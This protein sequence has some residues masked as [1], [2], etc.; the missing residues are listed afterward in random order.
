MSMAYDLRLSLTHS[1]ESPADN[2]RHILRV[3][4]KSI[5][6]QQ[7][8][9]ACLL[10]VLPEPEE[11]FDGT[12]FFGNAT[13]TVV[14][15]E[16]HDKMEIRMSARVELSPPPYVQGAFS[17]FEDLEDSLRRSRDLSSGSPL[18]FLG[19]SPRLSPD[20]E[21]AAFAASLFRPGDGVFTNVVRIGE[22]L[23]DLM[24]FDATATTVDTDPVDAFRHRRGVCQDYSHI[25]ILALRSLGI[26]AG[27]VSGFLR[28]VPPPGGLR[29]EGADAMH[30]WVQ[31][32]C[33]PVG[34]WMQYDP[35]NACLP[36]TDHIV[37][38]L[39]RDYADVSPIIGHLRASGELTSAQA[40]DVI[41][42]A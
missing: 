8:V 38:G 20:S 18:H 13:T 26:P 14:H 16:R 31:A 33:G 21:I 32:W 42:L 10:D 37:V 9:T 23:H 25:M 28:T 17:D 24:A 29:L 6:G 40:V 12:D 36:V 15:V 34:G 2:G 22:A 5:T 7:H 4:P 1:Y 41:E 27:Y 35:T 39:G 3:K 19:P 11:R 30:A